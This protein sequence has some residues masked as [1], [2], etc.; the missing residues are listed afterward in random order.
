MK[1]LDKVLRYWRVKVA[2]NNCPENLD[3]VFDIGCDDGYLLKQLRHITKRQDGVDPRLCV[4]SIG[5]ESEIK[6]G[7][8]PAVIEDHQ[9]Q[10][11]Y[12]AIF[13]L[14]VFEHFTEKDIQQSASVI[15]RM[16]S[17][18]GRLIVTVPHPFVD[19]ILDVLLFLRLIEAETLDEHHGFEPNELLTYFSETLR[20]VK[21]E[22]F[23]FGLNNVF[24]FEKF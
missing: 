16:L 5:L 4:D 13:A 11:A 8:F 18:G 20:L 19:K 7:F 6:K 15:S 10:G 3:N 24:V 12:D 23:Q 21:C 9:M 2:L 17:P 1:F 22:R 14:A